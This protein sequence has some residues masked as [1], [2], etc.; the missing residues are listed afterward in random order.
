MRGTRTQARTLRCFAFLVYHGI[1]YMLFFF[2]V[3]L[4][5]ITVFTVFGI[6][7]FVFSSYEQGVR[8]GSTSLIGNKESNFAPLK[9]TS[10]W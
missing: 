5:I 2:A 4:F 6:F 7:R 1:V 3:V 9:R 10:S 8:S